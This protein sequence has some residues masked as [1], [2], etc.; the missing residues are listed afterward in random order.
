M[1]RLRS[2]RVR[3]TPLTGVTSDRYQFLGLEQ[4]EPTFG[5]PLVGPSSIGL[6]PIPIGQVYQVVSVS[7]SEGKRYWTPLVG[8]G[9]TVGVISIYENGAL[10]NGDNRFQKIHGLNFV[11]AG[12]TIETPPVD[13]PFEGVGIATIRIAISEIV[14]QGDV[15]QIL[16]NT[17]SG[18]VNGADEFV[19][20]EVN[21]Y[22]G[23]GTTSPVTK[24]HVIGDVTAENFIGRLVGIASTAINVNGGFASVTSL[25]VSGITTL[26][27]VSS[28]NINST[29]IVTATTFVGNLTGTATTATNLG[30]GSLGEI[31]YQVNSGITSFISAS[32]ASNK[33]LKYDGDT[34][35]P[36]WVDLSGQ[37]TSVD[38]KDNSVDANQY[39]LFVPSV[40]VTS[41]LKVNSNKL[42]FNPNTS[43]IG[44]GTTVPK[45]NLHVEGTSLITGITT[46]GTVQISSGIVTATSGIVTY[47]GDGSK[48]LNLTGASSGTYGD[49]NNTA[50]ITVDENGRITNITQT[51]ISGGSGG[52]SGVNVYDDNT[53]IGF[54]SA[55]NFRNNIS[56]VS[57]GGTFAI[58]CNVLWVANSSG[59]HTTNTK[60]GIGTTTPRSDLH[61]EGTALITGITTIGLVNITPTGII[62][63]S[64]P[65]ITTI[66]YYGDGSKLSGITGKIGI[67]SSGNL[68]GTGITLINF[69]GAGVSSVSADGNSGIATITIASVSGGTV[70]SDSLWVKTTPSNIGIYTSVNVG[71]GTTNPLYKLHV[72]GIGSTA[73]FVNGD[74]RV[75]GKLYDSNNSAGASGNILSST[76]IGISWITAPTGST[77]GGVSIG[78]NT[79]VNSTYYPIF[80]S[81]ITGTATSVG[82]S[83]SKL[84]FNPSTGNFSATQFTS[85]SDESQKINIEPI[86]NSIDIIT[87]LNGVKF[88]W[89]ENNKPSYG[90]IAQAVEKV[91]PELVETQSNGMKSVNYSNMIALL[92]EAIKVQELRIQELESRYNV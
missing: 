28:G 86:Q 23:L 43:R 64:S 12:V 69:T 50:Q 3:R 92:I 15:G 34:N 41:E 6:N 11:G 82:V 90:L 36:V 30:S 45:T 57:I 51:G 68:V 32:G 60:V 40:G 14:N 21:N 24:L 27:T 10:P 4:A 22:V 67:S 48:L 9:T 18:V 74:A 78:N 91:I 46:I 61:V 88:N 17:P 47:Y 53:N 54:T 44:I 38:I 52:T 71:I 8:F 87:Q 33:F 55:L 83:S 76:G 81:S 70:T 37:I 77:G 62:T 26:G 75:T 72:S 79:T 35:K 16:Y 85:L 39:L 63:S 58:D 89:K 19:Y 80:S 1:G 13:G 20:N 29:G 2:G 7:N 66:T 5:D 73:L 25:Y 59:I 49:S 56:V 84:Q 65:G 42:V 31:P